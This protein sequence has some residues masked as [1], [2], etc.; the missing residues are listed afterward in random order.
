MSESCDIRW[1]A[2]LQAINYIY[3][4]HISVLSDIYITLCLHTCR[5]VV[6][7][8][9]TMFRWNVFFYCE[10]NKEITSMCYCF[11]DHPNCNSS[12]LVIS[13]F[14]L[15]TTN[16]PEIFSIFSLLT[17]YPKIFSIFSLL[18]SYPETFSILSLLTIYPEIFSIF[19]LL[20]SYPEI[21]SIYSLLTSYPEICS[22]FIWQRIR[23]WSHLTPCNCSLLRHVMWS[24]ILYII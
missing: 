6:L 12:S 10:I 4:Y 20:T 2:Y 21:C 19:S 3:R 8:I 13:F 11:H 5:P 18:T 22:I 7:N 16:Y 14:S 23:P 24:Q 15:M 17:S 9:P 1:A